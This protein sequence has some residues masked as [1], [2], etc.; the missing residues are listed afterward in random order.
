MCIVHPRIVQD[1]GRGYRPFGLRKTATGAA[2]ER[3]CEHNTARA[4]WQAPRSTTANGGAPGS[5]DKERN[6]PKTRRGSSFPGEHCLLLPPPPSPIAPPYQPST[7]PKTS[8]SRMIEMLCEPE[9]SED[10]PCRTVL[11]SDDLHVQ[12]EGRLAQH[13]HPGPSETRRAHLS[14][15]GPTCAHPPN[16]ATKPA[17]GESRFDVRVGCE[18][19]VRIPSLTSVGE[20][21]LGGAAW[22]FGELGE[23]D[24]VDLRGVQRVGCEPAQDQK[25]IGDSAQS[26]FALKVDVRKSRRA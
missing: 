7:P 11:E 17:T 26:S 15:P 1:R 10:S 16:Q 14:P 5:V 8:S 4:S 12:A 21:W 3:G 13:P 20:L 23:P 19:W 6:S 22:G 25:K 24:R 2:L 9:P 18:R